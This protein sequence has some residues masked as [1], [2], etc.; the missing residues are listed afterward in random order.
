MLSWRTGRESENLGFH[1]YREEDGERVRLTEALVAGSALAS[2]AESGG[3]RT[4]SI[5]DPGGGG[6]YWLEAV[7]LYGNSTWYGPLSGQPAPWAAIAWPS[8]SA[9]RCRRTTPWSS[10][11]ISIGIDVTPYLSCSCFR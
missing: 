4:Y 6:P 5:P 2:G 3:T 9:I 11:Q 7:D 8:G 1:V 10:S